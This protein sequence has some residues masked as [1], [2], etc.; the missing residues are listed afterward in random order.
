MEIRKQ[1][2][3]TRNS[4]PINEDIRLARA[5][6]HLAI[7]ADSTLLPRCK[8]QSP[9]C[10]CPHRNNAPLLSQRQINLRRRSF[11]DRIALTMQLVLFHVLYVHRLKC[12]KPHMESQLGNL[13]SALAYIGQDLPRKVQ[14]SVG[15]ATLPVVSARA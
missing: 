15:A 9:H 13:N 11:R 3:T 8:L 7:P 1:A 14:A 6:A 2:L 10:S 4:I 5:S 12:P